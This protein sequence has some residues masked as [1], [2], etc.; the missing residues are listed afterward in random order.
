VNIKEK[1]MHV[2]GK[3]CSTCK[4]SGHDPKGRPVVKM[5]QF[6]ADKHEP[7]ASNEEFEQRRYHKTIAQGSG[8]PACC[9][10]GVINMV[11]AS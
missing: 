8:C 1:E 4:G 7:Y 9:G 3:V 5:I 11:V 6:N 2:E 10:L